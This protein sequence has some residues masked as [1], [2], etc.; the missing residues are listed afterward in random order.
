MAEPVWPPSPEVQED[1]GLLLM[2]DMAAHFETSTDP[3]GHT[4]DELKH[5]D[6]RPLILS[7]ELMSGALEMARHATIEREG[8]EGYGLVFD[9]SYL[10]FYWVF[11]DMGTKTKKGK[12][13]IPPRPFAWASNEALEAVSEMFGAPVLHQVRRE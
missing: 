2:L 4:W 13:I 5:R 8:P 7:G 11:Q 12:Q 1:I 6:G 10:P 9:L 3:W